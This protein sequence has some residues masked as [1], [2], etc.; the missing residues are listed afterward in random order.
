MGDRGGR[1]WG[2]EERGGEKGEEGGVKGGEGGRVEREDRRGGGGGG[3]RG[4]GFGFDIFARASFAGRRKAAYAAASE[5]L[6]KIV[7]SMRPLEVQ[8]C[9]RHVAKFL[10]VSHASIG[11]V[12]ER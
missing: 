12:H 3:R 5:G 8:G 11:E 7:R 9:Q 4:R 10:R 1:G 2:N 6:A